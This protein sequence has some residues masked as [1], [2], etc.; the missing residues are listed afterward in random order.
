MTFNEY[1]CEFVITIFV[2]VRL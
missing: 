1:N 2:L